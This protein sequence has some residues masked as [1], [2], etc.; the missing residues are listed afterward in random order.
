MPEQRLC[1]PLV[2][3][4]RTA[5]VLLRCIE[6]L[7]AQVHLMG[8]GGGGLVGIRFY[9]GQMPGFWSGTS[10]LLQ[11]NTA[12]LGCSLMASEY[13]SKVRRK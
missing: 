8:G 10:A 13:Y 2:D 11:K 6:R 9:C 1:H 5:A 4:E 12:S 3:L 7:H